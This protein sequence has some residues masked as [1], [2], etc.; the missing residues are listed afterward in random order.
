MRII[1]FAATIALTVMPMNVSARQASYVKQAGIEDPVNDVTW[2]VCVYPGPTTCGA[3]W[4]FQHDGVVQGLVGGNVVWSGRWSKLAHYVYQYQFTYAGKS[5]SEWVR[6]S[7]PSGSGRPTQ[8]MGYPDSRMTTAHRQ[9]HPDASASQIV[10]SQG[11]MDASQGPAA[12][13]ASNSQQAGIEDPVNDV[14]WHVCVYPGPAVGCGD[15][16]FL[17]DGGVQGLVGGNVVWSGRWSKLAHYVYQYQ[18]TYAGKSNSEWVRFAD[19]SGSG[20]ATQLMGYPDSRMTAA[21]RVGHTDASKA[22]TV[23]SQGQTNNSQGPT[24]SSQVHK[25]PLSEWL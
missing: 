22:P 7:D 25:D 3:E 13:Q 2:Q 23:S 18:F 16:R 9:G 4:R 5:N 14:T 6:F 1:L 17:H 12:V 21:H 15:W 20:R 11:P 8:L 10:S 19:Q 24:N